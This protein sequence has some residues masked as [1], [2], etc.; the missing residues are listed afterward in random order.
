[1]RAV[2]AGRALDDVIPGFSAHRMAL[3]ARDAL[4]VAEVSHVGA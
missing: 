4:E 1:M 2:A 3:V